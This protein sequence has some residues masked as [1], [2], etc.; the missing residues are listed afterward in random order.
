M[1]QLCL[2]TNPSAPVPSEPGRDALVAHVFD[3]DVR[4]EIPQHPS[5]RM[6]VDALAEHRPA[7]LESLA[8][9]LLDFDAPALAR[10]RE[11]DAVMWWARS[12]GP[13]DDYAAARRELAGAIHDELRARGWAWGD[14]SSGQTPGPNAA[15]GGN[16]AEQE[17]AG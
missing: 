6:L 7:L 17:T 14:D 9:D 15:P 2:D 11:L 12:Q 16:V 10:F 4:S 3:D 8:Q 5:A 1:I 13:V